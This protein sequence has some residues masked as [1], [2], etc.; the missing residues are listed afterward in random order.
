MISVPD[1]TAPAADRDLA[2][3]LPLRRS[4]RQWGLLDFVWIQSGLAIATWAFLVGGVTASYVGFWD[5]MWTMVLGNGI[6]ATLM[7]CASAVPTC[8]WGTE[9]HIFHR[10]IYG[11]AGVLVVL[12]GIT[13]I[14]VVGWTSILAVMCGKAVTQL[15]AGMSGT[16]AQGSG[17]AVTAVAI[18]ALFIC[19][20]VL[21]RGARGIQVLNRFV[22]PGLIAMSVLL[23]V[24]IFREQ[25]FAEITAAPPLAPMASRSSNLMLALELNIAIGMSWWSLAGNLGRMARTQRAALWGSLI[26][27]VPVGVLAQMVGLT[28]ALVMGSSDPTEWML[29]I[30]GTVLAV[31]ILAF[32]GFANLT[33]MAS[34]VYGIVQAFA[35]HLGPR[36]QRFGWTGMAAVY[37]GICGGCVF[38]TQ[39]ALYDQFMV[40]VAWIQA[41]VV[42]A[43]GVTLADYYWLR[44]RRIDLRDLYDLSPC[45]PYAYWHG[46][47]YAAFLALAVGSVVYVLILNPVT[48]AGAPIFAHVGATIPGVLA[49]FATHLAVTRLFVIPG[50]SGGYPTMRRPVVATP[51]P[52][53]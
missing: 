9:H 17:L 50:G 14:P 13:V 20:L 53:R 46:I 7:L 32:I 1:T 40:F 4:D 47:N 29:P 10:S 31:V 39:T 43:I 12:F 52:V 8:K 38:L 19:W 15:Y 36:A 37:L 45:A 24:A 26:G 11:P 44:H 6:G 34:M 41:A 33:S 2:D 18:A 16:A 42:G 23:L 27:Y 51:P 28:A 49:A 3:T 21:A 35:Q 48:L 25:S 30:F 22:A 5:G